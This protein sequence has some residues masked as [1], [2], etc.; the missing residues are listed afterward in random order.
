[1]KYAQGEVSFEFKALVKQAVKSADSDEK[2][3]SFM[4]VLHDA[5]LTARNDPDGLRAAVKFLKNS[6]QGK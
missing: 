4:N 6:K 3:D 5:V 1:M 2:L